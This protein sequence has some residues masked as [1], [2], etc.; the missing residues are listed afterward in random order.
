MT[1]KAYADKVFT[2]K[3]G[4]MQETVKL[5]TCVP[6]TLGCGQ[7]VFWVEGNEALTQGHIYSR[8]GRREFSM[9][10]MCEWC[11]D[12]IMKDTGVD[13]DDEDDDDNYGR[14]ITDGDE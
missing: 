7:V 11:F 8:A 2:M 12:Q 14:D 9:T 4:A 13:D 3:A 10:G 5:P 1:D 6:P